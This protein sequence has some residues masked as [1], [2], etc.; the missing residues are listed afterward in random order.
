[1]ADVLTGKNMIQTLDSLAVGTPLLIDV[2]TGEYTQ[3]IYQGVAEI[4]Y[5]TAYMFYD[6]S[7]IDGTFGETKR[8]ILDNPGTVSMIL[9][10]NDPV[11]VS[12]LLKEIKGGTDMK[13]TFRVDASK[14]VEAAKTP[15]TS[16]PDLDD[17][18]TFDLDDEFE[19]G[20]DTARGYMPCYIEESNTIGNGAG[21]EYTIIV[22]VP[23]EE[24]HWQI[25][26]DIDRNLSRY[27]EELTDGSDYTGSA[28]VTDKHTYSYDV[29]DD[30]AENS[31]L[32]RAKITVVP[33]QNISPYGEYG[34]DF[35]GDSSEYEEE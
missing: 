7:G 20:L 17:R 24:D 31:Q 9:D 1:M 15:I 28:E 23:D 13:R 35:G 29:P 14:K 2:G 12:R 33:Y 30:V 26:E 6:G 25:A 3:V 4:Q 16:F 27:I 19:L 22:A 21:V 32:Y 18:F 5:R 11:E 10:D 8:F 34:I